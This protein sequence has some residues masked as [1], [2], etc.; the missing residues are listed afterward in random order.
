MNSNTIFYSEP[1]LV[2]ESLQGFRNQ[3]IKD[4]DKEWGEVVQ[5]V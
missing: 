1:V 3:A 4:T 2:Q 5:R